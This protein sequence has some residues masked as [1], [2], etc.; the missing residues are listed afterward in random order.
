MKPGVWHR[1]VI[2]VKCATSSG[3][4]GELRT[5][6]DTVPACVVKNES[7]VTGGRFEVRVSSRRRLLLHSYLLGPTL[8]HHVS[9]KC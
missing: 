8:S 3:S 4:K 7:V 2:S 6:I 5:W 9:C 1:L